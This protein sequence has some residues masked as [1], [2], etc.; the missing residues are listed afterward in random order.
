MAVT[1]TSSRLLL[2]SKSVILMF[3]CPVY[4]T[5][6][7]T[8]PMYEIEIVAFIG[9]FRVKLPSKSVTVPVLVPLIRI[10]APITD[11]KESDT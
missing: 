9:T 7:V 6:C 2:S 5:S 3:S 4:L 11:P 1:T 10:E 8:Y